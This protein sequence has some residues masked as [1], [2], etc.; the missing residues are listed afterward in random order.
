MLQNRNIQVAVKGLGDGAWDGCCRHH[1]HIRSVRAFD[2]LG[3]LEHAEFVLLI[4]HH[5]TEFFKLCSLEEEGVRADDEGGAAWVW[6][7]Q[8]RS[9]GGIL[10]AGRGAQDHRDSEGIEDAAE[11]QIMLLGQNLGWCHQGRLP[12]RLVGLNHGP[13]SHHGLSGP[14]IALEEAVHALWSGH[15][16]RNLIH[17]HALRIGEHKRQGLL[18]PAPSRTA[19]RTRDTSG[20]FYRGMAR[21]EDELNSKKDIPY[22]LASGLLALG[23]IHRKMN[24]PPDI[25]QEGGFSPPLR[26]EAGNGA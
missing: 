4:D 14:Y 17:H 3:A 1:K 21:A 8:I 26:P 22:E 7:K 25:R 24:G 6:F 15:I 19:S 23:H 13:Q 20:F 16:S 2:Q 11:I 10:A 12:P 5:Q 9:L 18:D